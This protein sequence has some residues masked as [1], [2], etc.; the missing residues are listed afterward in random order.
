MCNKELKIY[1]HEDFHLGFLTHEKI[2]GKGQSAK[3]DKAET[4][5]HYKWSIIKSENVFISWQ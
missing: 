5:T 3:D 4:I 2:W 1:S